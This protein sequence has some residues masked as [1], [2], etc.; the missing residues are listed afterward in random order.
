M[1]A[2]CFY[3]VLTSGFYLMFF[4]AGVGM[5]LGAALR[6]T[7]PSIESFSVRDQVE[8]FYRKEY[9]KKSKNVMKRIKYEVAYTE[10]ASL[11]SKP[12]FTDYWL[13]SMVTIMPSDAV[14][15]T[16]IFVGMFNKWYLCK[17][18]STIKTN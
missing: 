1:I 3:L 13:L 15:N 17:N 11:C 6:C 2:Y 10:F 14:Q 7:K 5:G 12:V 18:E 4:L 8:A 16:K 9:P